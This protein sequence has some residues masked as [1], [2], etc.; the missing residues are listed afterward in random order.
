MSYGVMMCSNKTPICD[1]AT[2]DFAGEGEGVGP[3]CCAD[4][5]GGEP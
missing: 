5:Y 3:F 2:K 1:G 4:A